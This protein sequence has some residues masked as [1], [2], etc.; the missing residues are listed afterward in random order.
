M[1][2]VLFLQCSIFNLPFFHSSI[3]P[4]FHSSILPL[5]TC[6]AQG[7]SQ[8]EREGNATR[9]N[10]NFNPHSNDTT[11][12][13]VVPKGI[14]VWS[15][16]R[17]FGDIQRTD[18]DTVPHLY[19]QST[20]GTGMYGQYNTVGS[21]YTARLSRIFIDR[22]PT[23][24]AFFTDTYDQVLRQ[25]DEWH[26]TNSLSP[27]TNLS[28]GSCGDKT[29][30]EDLVDARFAVNAGKKTGLG[31]DL[32][33]RYARGYFQSQNNSH[34][35]AT[36]YA[37]HL[38]DRYQAH[39]LFQT[40]HQKAAENGGI[41]NDDYI[42]HPE[43]FS[44][45]YSDNEIPV[46]LSSNWNRNDHQRLFLSHRYSVGFYRKV[47]MT[48]EE[49]EAKKFALEAEAEKKK[50]EAAENPEKQAAPVG[51][52]DNAKIADDLPDAQPPLVSDSLASDRISVTSKA[53]ADSLIAAEQEPVDSAD[54]FVKREFVPVTS[55]IHTAEVL[56][57]NHIYQAYSTPTDFYAD[58]Y[59]DRRPTDNYAGDSIYDKTRYLGLRN[60][61]A[62]GLL[63]GFNKY[64]PAG[65]KAFA[66]HELRRFD[67]P[68]FATDDS[69]VMHRWTEH[70]VSVGGQLTKTLGSALHYNLLAEVWVAGEDAGEMRL[71]GRADLNLRLFGDTIRLDAVAFLHRTNPAFIQRRYHAKHFWWDNDFDKQTHTHL[72][73]RLSYKKTHTTLRVALDEIEKYTYLGMSYDLSQEKMTQV[74]ATFRQCDKSLAVFTAQLDQRLH[75]GPLNWD[76]IVTFQTTTDEDVLPLPKV[77]IFSNL[78]LKFQVAKVLSVELGASA[79]WF[80]EYY[81][82]EF[83]PQLNQF[84]VA[85]AA[86]EVREFPRSKMGNFPFVDA[87]ANLHLKHARFFVMMTNV[88]GT[89]FNRMSF[90]TP[91][92]P[93]NRSVL[94]L[95][96]SWNFFN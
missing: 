79:T 42:T 7:I 60:T 69:L 93:L 81:V 38:G 68:D 5:S 51:R 87:Y 48:P 73:G 14:Y 37:S 54:V 3:L 67:M 25:P 2:V 23:T 26:F 85:T 28:Y 55:F 76:N 32:D 16:D 65:L 74:A 88:T 24:Q 19:P 43:L 91:H 95:G 52:P 33:Y 70:S 78:Y 59:F 18:V 83:L 56:N 82:P 57:Q 71:D 44:E 47:P 61:F 1:L 6:S 15:V 89:S 29:N 31:F 45:D 92:Y 84:A 20:M 40:Y 12:N 11:K 21:N 30:G 22:R 96:V 66:S 35:N 41:T 50:K 75:L 8:V 63:E 58:T 46:F 90:L 4:F 62:I 39:L 53:Q 80:T 13:K 10:G 77:N 86:P 27:I 64:V 9:S 17:H 36:F 72:E 94:H 34:F 49:I